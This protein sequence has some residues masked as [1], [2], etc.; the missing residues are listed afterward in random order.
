[1]S[2]QKLHART[3][4]SNGKLITFNIK[5]VIFLG[6]SFFAHFLNFIFPVVEHAMKLASRSKNGREKLKRTHKMNMIVASS[7]LNNEEDSPLSSSHV[8]QYF[9][10]SV[11]AK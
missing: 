3:Y 10:D 8:P 6:K 4:N 5:G 11:L 7:R 9:E 2:L 1:M